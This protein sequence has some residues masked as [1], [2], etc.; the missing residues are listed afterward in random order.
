MYKCR[1]PAHMNLQKTF[2]TKNMLTY[3]RSISL[4]IILHRRTMIEWGRLFRIENNFEHTGEKWPIHFKK[5]A[6]CTTN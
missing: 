2:S 5:N 6:L 3:C 1:A 4:S